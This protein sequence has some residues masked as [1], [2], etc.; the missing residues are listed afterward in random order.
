MH[1]FM[2]RKSVVCVCVM[3]AVLP[4]KKKKKPTTSIFLQYAYSY[5][6]AMLM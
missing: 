2:L 5:V 3:L 1:D 6:P 4:T